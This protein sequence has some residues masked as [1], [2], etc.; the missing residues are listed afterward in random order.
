MSDDTD[1][2]DVAEW[3]GDRHV[4]DLM[5][6]F[7]G[8]WWT[9]AR[10]RPQVEGILGS[11]DLVVAAVHRST[12]RLVGFARVLTDEA[13]LAIVLD[14]IVAP[15]WQRQ[16]VGK[17]LM[18]F[19]V[20]HE[21]LAAVESVELVCQAALMPFYRAWDFTENVGGSRLMRRTTNTAFLGVR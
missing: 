11:S 10:T 21:R 20:E 16:G 12:H 6:L 18:D 4:N 19:V 15:D 7:G 5:E 3:T 17:Q 9:S 2:I 1:Q 8:Q 14:V 13:F